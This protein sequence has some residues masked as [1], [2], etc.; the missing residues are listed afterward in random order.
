MNFVDNTAQLLQCILTVLS[1]LVKTTVGPDKQIALWPTSPWLTRTWRCHCTWNSFLTWFRHSFFGVL[2]GHVNCALVWNRW[3]YFNCCLLL[4]HKLPF[5]SIAWMSFVFLFFLDFS[6]ILN[7]LFF[8]FVD[9]GRHA[10]PSSMLLNSKRIKRH[11][12]YL[13]TRFEYFQVQFAPVSIP[14]QRLPI[15]GRAL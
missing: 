4:K 2:F 14:S 15:P 11:L 6:T 7:V 8:F 10:L 9:T 1:F 3:N 12:G 13:W 5:L